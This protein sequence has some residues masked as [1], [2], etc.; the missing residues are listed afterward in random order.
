MRF[1]PGFDADDRAA[2][3]RARHASV[4]LRDPHRRPRHVPRDK[5]RKRNI[6]CDTIF[7]T[8]NA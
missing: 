3:K 2:A 5:V 1:W 4:L 7:Y 8:T 6:F